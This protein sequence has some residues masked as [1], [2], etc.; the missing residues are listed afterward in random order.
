[1]RQTE[2]PLTD[3]HVGKDLIDQV[4]RPLRHPAGAAAWAEPA[5]LAREGHEAIQSA[6]GAPKSGEAAGQ[7]SAP[8]EVAKLLLHEARKPLA[9]PQRRCVRT[10]G[11]EMVTNDPVQ[12]RRCGIARC[13]CSRRLRHAPS[14]GAPRANYSTAS[15]QAWIVSATQRLTA[16]VSPQVYGTPPRP[17][18]RAI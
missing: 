9:I 6:G 17:A 10:E 1:M 11:L 4:R 12:E 2:D 13:V 15:K 3:W 18:H 5:A 14:T 16:G 7:T 8:Q